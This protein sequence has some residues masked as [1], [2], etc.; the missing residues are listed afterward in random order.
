[1]VRKI[2]IAVL[3]LLVVAVFAFSRTDV[4]RIY[5]PS[6]TGITAKQ[7]CSLH[8][9]SGLAPDRARALYVDPLLQPAAGLIGSKVLV[10]EQEVHTS[11]LG[12][13]RQRAVDVPGREDITLEHL[14]RM[15]GGLDIAERADGFDPN[16]DMLFTQ[17]DMATW[18][19][20]RARL[21]PP[22]VHWQYMSG[23][24]VLAARAL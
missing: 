7:I 20:A 11:V 5:L 2:L 10:D 19:S 9:V 13:Y 6:A 24:T 15:T 8:F 3:M 12:L 4:S 16:S 18:A 22:G 17:R 21:H 23:N 1:M 14:L